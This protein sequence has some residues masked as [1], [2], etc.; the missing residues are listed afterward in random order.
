MSKIKKYLIMLVCLAGAVWSEPSPYQSHNGYLGET[1]DT[2]TGALV[3]SS[4]DVSLPGRGG[5]GIQIV[6]SYN[7]KHYK[8]ENSFHHL[9]EE[10]G[11]TNLT[12]MIEK[13][14]TYTVFTGGSSF[15]GRG[16]ASRRAS[17]TKVERYTVLDRDNG[18]PWGWLKYHNK[19]TPGPAGQFSGYAGR[20]WQIGAGGVLF[21]TYHD[22]A[23]DEK[24]KELGKSSSYNDIV[25]QLGG[26]QSYYFDG[27]TLQPKDPRVKAF[28]RRER[29]GYVL[30]DAAGLRYYFT[31]FYF[32]KKLARYVRRG[33]DDEKYKKDEF[34][35]SIEGDS[36]GF[37]L[38]RVEN[39][40]G[41]WIAYEYAEKEIYNSVNGTVD[42]Q[43]TLYYKEMKPLRIYNSL[44][45]E[46]KLGYNKDNQINSLSYTGE[47]GAPLVWQYEYDKDKQMT[48]AVNPRGERTEYTYKV[49]K[50]FVPGIIATVKNPLGA[51]SS[52]TYYWQNLGNENL[53]NY[54]VWTKKLKAEG[55]EYLW[56]YEH[57]NGHT[58][59]IGNGKQFCFGEITITDPRNI[60]TT[61]YYKNGYPLREFL[62]DQ[63]LTE[64]EWDYRTG[65]K[66]K[67]ITVKGQKRYV[68]EYQD[69]DKYGNPGRIIN[70]GDPD[71]AADDKIMVNEYLH[72]AGQSA[73]PGYA[74]I[75]TQDAEAKFLVKQIV[76]SY[77][78]APGSRDKHNEVYFRY[79]LKGNLVRKEV[80]AA[81][82]RGNSQTIVTAYTYD[83][84]GELDTKTLPAGQR[85]AYRN[86]Y[87]SG[88]EYT[89]REERPDGSWSRK[90]YGKRTGLLLEEEDS[91]GN[92]TKYEYDRYGFMTRQ[93]DRKTGLQ[94]KN[95][96]TL[97]PGSG[98]E[99][100]KTDVYGNEEK[101]QLDQAGRKK[102]TELRYRGGGQTRTTLYEYHDKAPQLLAKVTDYAGRTT[103]TRYDSMDRPVLQ[104]NFDRTYTET[105][106]NDL[107]NYKEVYDVRKQ[108]ITCY[109]DAYGNLIKTVQPNGAITEYVYNIYGK[110]DRLITHTDSKNKDKDR[111]SVVEYKYDSINRLIEI[112]KGSAV[113]RLEYDVMDNVVRKYVPGEK[114]GDAAQEISYSYDTLNRPGRTMYHGENKQEEY[115]YY[116]DINN[117]GRIQS[118][119]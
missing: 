40:Y 3:L 109:Y 5:T 20:G 112:R 100:V 106:Y 6:R 65:N 69:Y 17:T 64:Y 119:K 105:R 34:L 31:N 72:H 23:C 58:Y 89:A 73:G 11:T 18:G 93:T 78:Q 28:L 1:V 43:R 118:V 116:T 90:T 47:D 35:F 48:A 39:D 104:I 94:E 12:P 103:E 63:V 111:Q 27:G 79:D 102:Q 52:Y 21:H 98:A 55:R 92:G 7:N 54:T 67:E 82:D 62:P 97:L 75:P 33:E 51:E 37:L 49:G 84:H 110:L 44:G 74:A 71:V 22:Y 10:A 46:V 61:H 45:N 59:D 13:V 8:T 108:K 85:L 80:I 4:T 42:G 2:L 83:A 53:N 60:K 77:V 66:L 81:D 32:Q 101:T 50:D 15:P 57:L 86:D 56:K 99:Y 88:R 29:D 96:Y 19:W 95:S 30:S 114:A 107:L 38:A 115:K 16:S 76:H 91:Y 36:Q 9:S 41:D 24:Y 68:T 117:L 70:Y 26:G 25:V 14:R 113:T 87:S